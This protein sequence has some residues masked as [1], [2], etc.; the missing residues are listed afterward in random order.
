MSTAEERGAGQIRSVVVIP[1]RGGSRGIPGK[2]LRT[3]GGVPLVGRSIRAARA[4]REVDLVVVSTDSPDIAATATRFGARV[5]DRPSV[6][7]GDRA[8]SE[9]A[10]VHAL[11]VL[12]NDGI[13]P[14]VVVLVQCTSPFTTAD[15]IDATVAAL[16]EGVD[17]AFTAVASHGFLW[18]ASAAGAQPVNH[19]MGHRPR[20]Q[21]REPE[22]LETG[23]V[24]AMDADGFRRAGHRFFGRTTFVVTDP[25]R[26]LE[27]DDH[28]QLEAAERLADLFDDAPVEPRLP[29]R[30]GALVCDFDGVMTDDTVITFEDGSEAVIASRRDGLGL[31]LLRRARADLP[32]MVLSSERNRVVAARC[33]K[34]D[35]ECIQGVDD[36]VAA[37]ETWASVHRIDLSSIVYM[38]NDVNDVGCMARVGWSVAPRDAH[39]AVSAIADTVLAHAGGRGA[40]REL[41]ELLIRHLASHQTGVLT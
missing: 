5:I 10:I 31:S 30:I 26:A 32:V 40:I 17:S 41:T 22:Y 24:Y 8:S 35:I 34:L 33:R 36:K 23:A 6:L 1:A 12:A 2:N 20:R 27:I 3:V 28:H 39:P 7:A 11:D 14:E 16:S 18:T 15:D 21:D 38:G 25:A 9:S 13:V 19:E 37:L 4:A 29:E